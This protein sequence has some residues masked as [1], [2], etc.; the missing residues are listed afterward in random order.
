MGNPAAGQVAGAP[1][2]DSKTAKLSG[3]EAI[4]DQINEVVG[5][6]DIQG[7]SQSTSFQVRDLQAK[8]I[9]HLDPPAS[10][11]PINIYPESVSVTVPIDT[12]RRSVAVA[13]LLDN[14]KVRVEKGWSATLELEPE[15]VTLRV[16]PKQ[17]APSY[18]LTR[19]EVLTLGSKVE[20][21]RVALI[22]P[23]G[24]ELLGAPEIKV[25]ATPTRTA[26]AIRPSPTPPP[27][28]STP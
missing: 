22:E 7:Q 15:I 17:K 14:V 27:S 8:T 6:V 16:G 3:P 20:T 11:I 24:F 4:L 12:E 1:F 10:R 2:L 25:R 23:D 5:K 21:H 26:T 18:R 19:P 28:D 13:V 9:D